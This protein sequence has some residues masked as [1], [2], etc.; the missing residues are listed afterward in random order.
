MSPRP[1]LSAPP[2]DRG[3]RPAPLSRAAF[4][5][6]SPRSAAA[7]GSSIR[8]PGPDCNRPRRGATATFMLPRRWTPNARQPAAGITL[9]ATPSSGSVCL[10][11][12]STIARSDVADLV[13]AKP[14]RQTYEGRHGNVAGQA[15]VTPA[16]WG[17][18]TRHPSICCNAARHHVHRA[19]FGRLQV[20]VQPGL[21]RGWAQQDA[22]SSQHRGVDLCKVAS[23]LFRSGSKFHGCRALH[24]HGICPN[25]P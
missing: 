17:L 21:S 5:V 18:H 23:R 10:P 19:A 15:T 2:K 12:G 22:V 25:S 7:P 9:S 4:R 14:F 24:P 16:H 3:A 20:A 1:V 6:P 11:P 8:V 13:A